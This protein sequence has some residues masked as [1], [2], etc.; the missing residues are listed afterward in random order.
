MNNQWNEQLMMALL[1]E[2]YKN[3]LDGIPNVSKPV[4]ELADDYLKKHDDNFEKAAKDLIRTQTI[5]CGTSGFLTGLGGILTLP[6]AIPANVSS[7][8]YVQLRMVAAI[9]YIGGYDVESYQVQSMAYA[10]LT[11]SA[12]TDVLKQTGIKIG[13]KTATA[14]INKIPSKVLV[15]INQRVGYKL[16]IKYGSKSVTN[17]AKLVP[18]AGGVISGA[19]DVESTRVIAKNAYKAFIQNYNEVVC[20]DDEEE[21]KAIE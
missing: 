15:R 7:I 17:L 12:I 20:Q 5:K 10:C 11:G 19:I 1:D 4:A 21:G 16:V 3:I 6:I 8:L 13:E 9:A 2:L 14:A 18:I